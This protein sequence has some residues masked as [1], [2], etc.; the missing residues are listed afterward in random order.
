MSLPRTFAHVV[1]YTLASTAL[2]SGGDLHADL[3]Q[4]VEESARKYNCTFSVGV[5]I[6]ALGAAL[7]FSSAGAQPS[8]KFAWGSVTK[9]WTGASIMQ[10]VARG[11][12]KLNE[13]A[14]P[15]IDAQLAAMKAGPFPKMNFTKL[16]DL[17]GP[18]VADVTI[19]DLLAMQSGIPD[20]DTANPDP[21]KGN[22]DP[23]RA[24]VY[25][26]PKHDYTVPTLM[27][28]PWVAL[29]QLT[30]VP[31]SGFHYSTTNFELL[32]LILAKFASVADYR[33]FNQ[34]V[35]LP[36]SYANVAK[37]IA[38]AVE[39]SPKD[40][41]VIAGYDRTSYNGQDPNKTG[42]I[43]VADVHGVF[44]GWSGADFVAPPRAVAEL[45]YALWGNTSALVPKEFR[46]LMIPVKSFYGLASQNV[47]FMGI[48]GGD[49]A[50]GHL[51]A[52]YGYDSIFAYNPDNDVAIAVASDIETSLQTQPSDAFCRVYNRVKNY[53]KG[54]PV[55][56]CEWK[57]TGYYGGKCV[58][59]SPLSSLLI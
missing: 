12:L 50:Y 52:T 15:H 58:C 10:L 47:G 55:Q 37:D 30:S 38:W 20:F 23:F 34:S 6:P 19:H 45:G 7:S 13:T 39:G 46:D 5:K 16:A 53:M 54:E 31:G 32:G 43:S 59:K 2:V 44:G 57:T 18:E 40:M 51:G 22:P 33:K 26:N 28:E 36:D 8:T 56:S 4:I 27:S 17:Y 11:A 21:S 48:A 41:G 35:F 14:A 49:A 29:H 42:G 9:M 1:L 3:Q 24:T 25:A